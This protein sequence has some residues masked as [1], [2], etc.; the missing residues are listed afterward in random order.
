MV[1]VLLGNVGIEIL[2]LDESEEEFIDNLDV[3]PRDFQH[4][5]VLLRIKR[6]S[7]RV[8]GRGD[9]PEE[10]LAEHVNHTRVHRLGDDLSVVGHVIEQLMQS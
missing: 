7:L 4:R 5:L 1:D 9:R 3:R 10:I 8:H 6:L 2:A